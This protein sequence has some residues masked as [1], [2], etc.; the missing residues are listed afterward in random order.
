MSVVEVLEERPD[1]NWACPFF[2]I[3]ATSIRC[4][5]FDSD[6]EAIL[7]WALTKNSNMCNYVI[8][9]LRPNIIYYVAG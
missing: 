5:Y 6:L 2:W 1:S 9:V 8:Q 7:S 3:I 4:T